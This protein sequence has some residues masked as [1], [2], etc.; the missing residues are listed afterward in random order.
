MSFSIDHIVIL[1]QDLDSASADYTSLGFTVVAGGE[2]TGGETHNALIAFADGT[3]LELIA[4]RRPAPEHVWWRHFA[5]GEGLIDVALL[6]M[7]IAGD[8]AAIRQRG[9]PFDD[10]IPGGRLRPD[11]QAIAWSLGRPQTPDLPFLCADVTPR[12]LRVPGRSACQHANGVVG[13][14]DLTMAVADL[15]A[16]IEHYQALLGKPAT[17]SM[18]ADT[19]L[20]NNA[21]T[22]TF[23]LGAA[24]ITLA[25]PLRN[26][27]LQ[28]PLKERLAKHGEGPYA[29]ALRV[30][31]ESERYP[32]NLERAHEVLLTYVP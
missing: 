11:G 18:P 4:F 29:L 22:T 20:S 24:T 2:H 9:L 10:P 28:N 17:T 16:S 25:A 27:N 8:I 12:S 7:N 5:T 3:Y 6:P 30:V 31:G 23:T 1:V 21:R 32:L 14:A 13:I 19:T 26:D 15:D